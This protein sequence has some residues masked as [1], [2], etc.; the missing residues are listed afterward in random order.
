MI[1]ALDRA[2]EKI[3]AMDPEQQRHVAEM[4]GA[5]YVTR[6]PRRRCRRKKDV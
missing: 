2:L 6:P 4:L 3:R 5:A 1:D